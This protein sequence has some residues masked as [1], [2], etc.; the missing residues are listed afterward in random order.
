MSAVTRLRPTLTSCGEA[1]GQRNIAQLPIIA[2]ISS[3]HIVDDTR[4]YI[5]LNNFKW[6]VCN[7]AHDNVQ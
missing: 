5:L 1:I 3:Y 6:F 7:S 2:V 4:N